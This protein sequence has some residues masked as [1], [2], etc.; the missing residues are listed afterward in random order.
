MFNDNDRAQ[1]RRIEWK[2]D[3]LL[4]LAWRIALTQGEAMADQA[5][6]VARLQASVDAAAAEAAS[7]TDVEASASTLLVALS[8][9]IRDNTGNPEALVALADRLDAS[10]AVGVGSTQSLAAAVAENTPSKPPGGTDGADGAFD[11]VKPSTKAN[12]PR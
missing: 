7:Q 1:A 11:D 6:A 8:Q 3:Q 9:I 10:T 5:E 2:L 12:G 4:W